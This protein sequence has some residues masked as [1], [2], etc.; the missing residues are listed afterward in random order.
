MTGDELERAIDFILKSQTRADAR[1]ERNEEQ[2]SRLAD[3]VEQLRQQ[4]ADS[5][6]RH[7]AMEDAHTNFV[8]AMTQYLE[9][10]DQINK[11]LR[12][13]DVRQAR[14]S[15]SLAESFRTSDESLREAMAALATRQERT[16]A[17]VDRMSQKVEALVKVVEEGRGGQ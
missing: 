4:G 5:Q 14:F 6:K 17:T 7:E 2:L 3:Q 9:T 11:S 12:E 1:S 13:T 8:R 10:Q 16:E 15:A